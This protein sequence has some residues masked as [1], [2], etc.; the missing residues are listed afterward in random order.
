MLRCGKYI[1]EK[2][3]LQNFCFGIWVAHCYIEKMTN[4]DN[5]KKLVPQMEASYYFWNRKFMR[6]FEYL[7]SV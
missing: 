2:H 5:D 7:Q 3:F 4:I 6:G 1:S